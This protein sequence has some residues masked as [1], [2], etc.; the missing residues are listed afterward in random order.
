MSK[1]TTKIINIMN[2]ENWGDSIKLEKI[3]LAVEEAVC[4]ES[5]KGTSKSKRLSVIK[6]ILKSAQKMA[7]AYRQS[8]AEKEYEMLSHVLSRASKEFQYVTDTHL[9][10]KFK[11]TPVPESLIADNDMYEKAAN[12]GN[13][14]N[15]MGKVVQVK[16]EDIVHAYKLKKPYIVVDTENGIAYN[17]VDLKRICDFFKLDVLKMRL[18]TNTSPRPAEWTFENGEGF[19]VSPLINPVKE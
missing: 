15:N 8:W 14:V 18:S 12:L 1:L 11:D 5:I 19:V 3:R 6:A 9:L 10:I 17:P 13:R 2:H 4:L 7:K 16:Y